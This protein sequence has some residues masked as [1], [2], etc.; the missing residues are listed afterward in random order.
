MI[1]LLDT[2]PC[3]HQ[4]AVCKGIQEDGKCFRYHV[5]KEESQKAKLYFTMISV[6]YLN[7]R[8]SYTDMLAA[9]NFVQGFNFPYHTVL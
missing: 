1:V 5:N 8:K 9:I 6:R 3:S 2:L 4:N 7:T